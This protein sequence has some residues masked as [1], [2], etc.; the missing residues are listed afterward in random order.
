MY[1]KTYD[2]FEWLNIEM[3]EK[4]RKFWFY[5]IPNNKFIYYTFIPNEI[6]K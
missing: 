6:I 5:D 4:S 2:Y 3:P 1:N